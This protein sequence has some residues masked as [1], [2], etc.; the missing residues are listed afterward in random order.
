VKRAEKHYIHIRIPALFLVLIM[1][2]S[3]ASCSHSEDSP[4]AEEPSESPFDSLGVE[5]EP[6]EI[7]PLAPIPPET[8]LEL[9]SPTPSQLLPPN[10][11]EQPRADDDFF[12]DAAF[13]GNS[14][15]DGF[16]MFSGIATSDYFAV[17]SMTVLGVSS[18]VCVTLDNG[19]AGTIIDGLTQKPYGKIYTLLGINEIGMAVDA[20]IEE[21]GS[22]LDKII[23][24][25]P[26]CD[27]YVMGI[28]PVSQAKSSS[29]ELF[30]MP[31]INEYNAA[32]KELAADKGCYYMDLVEALAG[33]DGFL[34]AAETSD[35]VHFSASLY[36]TWAEYVRTHYV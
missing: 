34:P 22:M 5:I 4:A 12:A 35:G 15:M 23:A 11:P 24:A 17:T 3:M 6:P 33:E 29:H 26:D 13:M 27:I 1:L 19:A 16:R 31:R 36:E 21:Y 18:S 7:K 25:Q 28:T 2:L 32:L 8:S 9:P 10:I 14:L 20:F 30:N